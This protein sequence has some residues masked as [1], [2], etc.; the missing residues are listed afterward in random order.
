MD[1]IVYAVIL[2]GG[3]GNRF[4]NDNGLPKQFAEVYGKT[5]LD[6]CITNF[7]NHPLV[8]K[9]IVVSNSEH[10]QRTKQIASHTKFKKIVSVVE[11]GVTR[12]A[13][14]YMGLKEILERERDSDLSNLKVLIQDSVRPN[15][16]SKL[17]TKIIGKLSEN[18][19]VTIAVPTTDTIYISDDKGYIK[20]IPE[21][22]D[23][24]KAQ[25]PQGFDF[26]TI[27]SAYEQ[28]DKVSRFK[29][30][31][32]ACLVNMV[33]PDEEIVILDGDKNNIKI[34]F[35]EDIEYFRQILNMKKS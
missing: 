28:L 26:N 15:T 13:S 1:R 11:G 12:G 14:S 20:T 32:D 8:D 33:F 29:Q 34:T 27:M 25:T 24:F 17:I 23:L 19:A 16:D 7:N 31:D 35:Y 2:S 10:V 6:Y 21:R 30:S 3:S 18:K 4:N 22:N 5:I 9:I